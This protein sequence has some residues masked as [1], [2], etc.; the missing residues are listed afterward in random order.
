MGG[1]GS[2]FAARWSRLLGSALDPVAT[3]EVD[4][5][6]E[7]DDAVF[8]SEEQAAMIATNASNA[9]HRPAAPTRPIRPTVTLRRRPGPTLWIPRRG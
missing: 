1:P 6:E 4:E 2:S 3:V 9:I 7:P 8:G 5:R